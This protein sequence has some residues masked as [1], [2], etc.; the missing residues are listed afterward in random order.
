MFQ[1]KKRMVLNPGLGAWRLKLRKS[2]CAQIVPQR[3]QEYRNVSKDIELHRNQGTLEA[4][5]I[6]VVFIY[7]LHFKVFLRFLHTVEV[8]GSSP[9]SPT[10]PLSE[11][12][13]ARPP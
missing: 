9:L 6:F 3:C 8:R 12:R 11:T 4:T 7:F 5:H 13:S 10:I 1:H 2:C